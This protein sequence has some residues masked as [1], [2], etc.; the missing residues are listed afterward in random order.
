MP[1]AQSQLDHHL[2]HEQPAPLYMGELP[3]D[4]HE[5]PARVIVNLCGA[6]PTGMP[7][8]A[9]I[10]TFPLHD[11]LEPQ[12]MPP[13]ADLERFLGVVHRYTVDS[14]SY[15]HCHAGL[16]RSGIAVA[17]YLHLYR[18]LPIGES[19]AQLRDRR[20][21]MVL[22]NGYFESL[23]RTWYGTDEERD[24]EGM[25]PSTWQFAHRGGRNND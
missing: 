16:N 19:I 17:A 8:G 11:T 13:R 7:I 6:F 1:P 23:L 25:S 9:T 3:L 2:V 18:G 4:Y 20:S 24:V 22:C 12:W 21:T 15:W 14:P 10:F 5:A